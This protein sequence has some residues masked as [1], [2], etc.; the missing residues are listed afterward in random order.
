MEV[1]IEPAFPDEFYGPLDAF[2]RKL[3]RHLYGPKCYSPSQ[4]VTS[5]AFVIIG[6]MWAF[7]KSWGVAFNA[8][9][10]IAAYLSEAEIEIRK[11]CLAAGFSWEEI[12][13]YR[14]RDAHWVRR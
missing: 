3:Q 1:L 5:P 9:D 11:H 4:H 12:D 14:N 8:A 6:D 13:A 2:E 10:D 7:A